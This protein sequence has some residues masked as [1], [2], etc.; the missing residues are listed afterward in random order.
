ME[1]ITIEMPLV[2]QCDV[3]SCGYNVN[4]TCH[5]KAITVGDHFN[6]GCDTFFEGSKHN[7]ETKRI[8]GVGACKVG[9]CKYNNDFECTAE[10]IIVGFSKHEINCLTYAI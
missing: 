10:N 5:A 3:S 7:K 6:P 8:A 1:K 2:S 4:D 9:T